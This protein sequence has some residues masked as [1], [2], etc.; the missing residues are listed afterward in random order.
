MMTSDQPAN[1]LSF[2]CRL[3]RRLITVLFTGGD[4]RH[5]LCPADEKV[6]QPVIDIVEKST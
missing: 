3:K 1:N 4:H 6:L 2:A 5:N